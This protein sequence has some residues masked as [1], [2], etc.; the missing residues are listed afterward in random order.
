[1]SIILR[2]GFFQISLIFGIN[3]PLKSNG[4]SLKSIES[5]N[6]WSL[7]SYSFLHIHPYLYDKSFFNKCFINDFA[8]ELKFFGNFNHLFIIF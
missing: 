1:M 5:K 3:G 2:F 4:I 7:I 6:Q 8:L